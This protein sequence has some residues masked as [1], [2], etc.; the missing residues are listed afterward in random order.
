MLFRLN[1]KDA[2]GCANL[3]KPKGILRNIDRVYLGLQ[4]VVGRLRKNRITCVD[5]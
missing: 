1:D 5:I 3:V 4:T 2:M